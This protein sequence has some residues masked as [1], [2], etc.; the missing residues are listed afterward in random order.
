MTQRPQIIIEYGDV[1]I[2]VIEATSMMGMKRS[3]LSWKGFEASKAEGDGVDEVVRIMRSITYPN[4]IAPVLTAEG[5]LTI[6]DLSGQESEVDFSKWPISIEILSLLPD[7]LTR[8]WE[9][10]VYKLNPHWG[11][12]D[13]PSEEQSKKAG[14]S[15]NA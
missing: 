7:R 3:I 15:A 12:I 10:A 5:K 6:Y 1:K 2:T 9:N 4:L 14:R 13:E 11:V 8:D